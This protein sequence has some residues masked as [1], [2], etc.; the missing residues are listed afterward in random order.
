[1]TDD[2]GFQR[3]IDIDGPVDLERTLGPMRLGFSDP[4][5]SVGPDECWHALRTPAGTATVRFGHRGERIEVS[6]WGDG[7]EWSVER[8]PLMVGVGD[9]REQFDAR[10]NAMLHRQARIQA[11]HRIAASC[12]PFSQ[13]IATI[14]GQRVTAG[15]AMRSWRDL[16]RIHGEV[17]PGPAPDGLRLAPSPTTIVALGYPAFHPLGIER[18]RAE[19]IR[20]TSRHG[21]RVIGLIDQPLDEATRVLRLIRGVGEWTESIV[22]QRALGDAD[23]PLVGDLHIPAQVCM[24]LRGEAGDDVA[25]LELLEPF[26]PFRALAQRLAL[27]IGVGPRRK[28]PR[29]RPLPISRF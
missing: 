15:E 14:L 22:R 29:Y 18:G 2:A 6:S 1:V 28:G 4:T 26:R 20:S 23:C 13:A 19:T 21:Q 7:A 27:S 25:M 11:G 10:S 24:A 3:I 5:W 9:H 17:A 16:V 12:D 8:G